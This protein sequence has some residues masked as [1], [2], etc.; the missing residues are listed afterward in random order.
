MFCLHTK[1]VRLVLLLWSL[2]LVLLSRFAC[3]FNI[4]CMASPFIKFD[5]L[6]KYV[7]SIFFKMCKINT[8]FLILSQR[9]EHHSSSFFLNVVKQ[10]PQFKLTWQTYYFSSGPRFP[11][12]SVIQICEYL[13]QQAARRTK[14]SSNHSFVYAAIYMSRATSSPPV[15]RFLSQQTPSYTFHTSSAVCHTV[16]S[17]S[18]RWIWHTAKA[19]HL[20][21]KH[22]SQL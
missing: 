14:V 15:G 11:S 19:I 13:T 20:S 22:D 2:W 8:N 4:A 5:R 12:Q 1:Y 6:S 3:S 10:T 21:L 16:Q 9:K 17:R 18:H 7:C